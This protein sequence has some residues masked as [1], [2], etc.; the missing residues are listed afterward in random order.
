MKMLSMSHRLSV[1]VQIQEMLVRKQPDQTPANEVHD[2]QNPENLST[3]FAV[4]LPR[5]FSESIFFIIFQYISNHQIGGIFC[6]PVDGFLIHP[7][8]LATARIIVKKAVAGEAG[9]RSE[10]R[11]AGMP[12]SEKRGL[13]GKVYTPPENCRLHKKHDCKGCFSCQHCSEDRCELCRP[14]MKGPLP[15]ERPPIAG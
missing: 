7:Y 8:F 1:W 9:R 4:F 14:Q 11:G 6:E 15:A 5:F 12:F 3:P 13:I 10:R 2:N